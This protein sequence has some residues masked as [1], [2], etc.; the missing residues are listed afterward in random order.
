MVRAL[1][2]DEYP[3]PDLKG[4]VLEL[5]LARASAFDVHADILSRII[6]NECIFLTEVDG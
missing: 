3:D 5:R 1:F 2:V 4:G 6:S